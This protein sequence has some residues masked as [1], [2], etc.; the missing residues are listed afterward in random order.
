MEEQQRLEIADRIKRLRQR[1]PFKQPQIAERLDI[2]LRAYQKLEKVGTTE[3]ERCEEL[4]DIH[5]DWSQRDPEW[6]HVS[7][8]WIWD[9]QERPG[10]LDLMSAL[11]AK[12]PDDRLNAVMA[13]VEALRLEMVATRTQLLA[14]IAKV[15]AA[16]EAPPSTRGKVEQR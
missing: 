8:G 12:S 3:Y 9:G 5:H 15:Q 6:A 14:E 16:L 13:A 10:D 11:P 7:A 2:G 1:S 4:A